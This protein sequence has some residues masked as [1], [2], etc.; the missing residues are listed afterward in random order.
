MTELEN[1]QK[2]RIIMNLTNKIPQLAAPK[3]KKSVFAKIFKSD[4][5]EG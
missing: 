4:K 5:K 3:V 1:E 2:N